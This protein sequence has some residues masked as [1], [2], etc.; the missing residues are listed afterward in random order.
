MITQLL[1]EFDREWPDDCIQQKC[2][3]EVLGR[4][5]YG[6]ISRSLVFAETSSIPVSVPLFSYVFSNWSEVIGQVERIPGTVVAIHDIVTRDS[7]ME[8][9]RTIFVANDRMSLKVRRAKF[10]N[11]FCDKIEI[12]L[13]INP[14][15]RNC[16]SQ[17]VTG[18]YLDPLT[19]EKQS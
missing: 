2:L 11:D 12:V 10:G 17:T 13:Q 5:N 14:Y 8:R 7:F 4:V 9:L 3:E 18:E 6:R 16:Q 15:E 19:G 1:S